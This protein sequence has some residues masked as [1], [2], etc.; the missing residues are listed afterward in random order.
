M[1][2]YHEMIDCRQI[3]PWP[4]SKLILNAPRTPSRR[5][6]NKT[7]TQQHPGLRAAPAADWP[8]LPDCG[9]HFGGLLEKVGSRPPEVIPT[10]DS[11]SRSAVGCRRSRTLESLPLAGERGTVPDLVR[12]PMLLA[13]DAGRK[14][15]FPLPGKAPLFPVS[16]ETGLRPPQSVHQRFCGRR[17]GKQRGQREETLPSPSG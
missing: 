7:S 15:I 5:V 12:L 16:S 3:P 11:G 17:G 8:P 6:P 10:Q 4:V 1:D 13:N 9:H 14:A 2:H